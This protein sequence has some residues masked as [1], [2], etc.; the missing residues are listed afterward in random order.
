[1]RVSQ[2]GPCSLVPFQ[3]CPVFPCSHT[4]SECFRTV[5]FRNFVPCSQKLANVP[6]F[7]SIF[8]QCS[9]WRPSPIDNNFKHVKN[10]QGILRYNND[11]DDDAGGGGGGDNDIESD[12]QWQWQWRWRW[13]WYEVAYLHFGHSKRKSSSSSST[14]VPF[15]FLRCLEPG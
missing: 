5:I 13:W 1:M 7:T 9:L 15:C 14:N 8:C 3:N 4:L 10:L 12:S 6:L 2:G 11:D